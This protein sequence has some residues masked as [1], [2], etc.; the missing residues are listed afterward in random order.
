MLPTTPRKRKYRVTKRTVMRALLTEPLTSGNFFSNLATEK[1]DGRCEVCAIGA[2][3]R[4]TRA[5]FFTEEHARQVTDNLCSFLDVEL[6]YASG[7]FLSVLSSEYEWAAAQWD[8][9]SNLIRLHALMV[10][11]G[12]CPSVLEFKA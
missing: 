8:S 12:M 1:D 6:A 10:A 3:L 9:G 11:E 4:N 5:N 7:N 2:I